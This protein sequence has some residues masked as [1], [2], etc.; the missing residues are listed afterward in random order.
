MQVR[1]GYVAIALN[2]ENSST[3]KTVTLSNLQKLGTSEQKLLRLQRLAHTNLENLLRVIRY[4][5]GEQI[6]LYRFTSKLFPFATYPLDFAWN[7]INLY[8]QQ[9]AQIGELIR[10]TGMRVSA[11]PDH[12]TVINSPDQKVFA[13][14][15]TDLEYHDQ[16]FTAMGLN[17]EYKLVLHLGGLYGDKHESIK[18]FKHNF[19]LLPPSVQR[20]LI[21]E[22][23]DKLYTAEDVLKI[24]RDLQLPMVLDLH[25]HF[26]NPSGD[27]NTLLPFIWNSWAT[28]VPKI[29][30]SSPK[31]G[32]RSRHHADYVDA[33]SIYSFLKI[34][35]AQGRDFDIMVEAK[36]K[37]KAMF[38]LI[39]D[40]CRQPDLKLVDRT[41]IILE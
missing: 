15:V 40:L 26:C 27:L 18:R 29:H 21:L 23:D 34:A 38:K 41:T 37:D 16:V 6:H 10:Q 11:H 24:C 30:V 35:Q 9:L 19:N 1:F 33:A 25:H 7:Y 39:T 14:S 5:V 28:D 20:R 17:E 22:N 12:F 8:G 2:L 31:D 32:L 36:M 3:S 4:N 13:N